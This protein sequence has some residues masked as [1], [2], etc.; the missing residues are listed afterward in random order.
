MISGH[1]TMFSPKSASQKPVVQKAEKSTQVKPRQL[2]KAAGIDTQ[3]IINLLKNHVI[4]I[5]CRISPYQREKT[6]SYLYSVEMMGDDNQP[7]LASLSLKG[8]QRDGQDIHFGDYLRTI[9]DLVLQRVRS[10]PPFKRKV[11]DLK[12]VLET[13]EQVP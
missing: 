2:L 12:M 10:I 7:N 13:L 9:L 8:I 6:Q 4:D 3:G 1:Y 5:I 11:V